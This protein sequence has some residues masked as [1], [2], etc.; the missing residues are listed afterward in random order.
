MLLPS[1]FYRVYY[2]IKVLYSF[3]NIDDI[4]IVEILAGIPYFI[5]LV[6][7]QTKRNGGAMLWLVKPRYLY[8]PMKNELFMMIIRMILTAI[9]SHFEKKKQ[10]PHCMSIGSSVCSFFLFIFLK[11]GCLQVF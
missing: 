4:I 5:L 11:K 10:D 2:Y 1:I 7:I 9:S 6:E 8:L 3:I